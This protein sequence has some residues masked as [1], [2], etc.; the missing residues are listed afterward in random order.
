[1]RY[2]GWVYL[3]CLLVKVVLSMRSLIYGR[4]V[5]IDSIL[6]GDR[7]DTWKDAIILMQWSLVIMLRDRPA[8]GVFPC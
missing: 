4:D 2:H 6:L 3:G 8:A 5:E 1:M 7:D